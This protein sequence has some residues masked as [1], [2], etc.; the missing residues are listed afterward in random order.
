M[1]NMT[2]IVFY[3]ADEISRKVTMLFLHH[4]LFKYCH[5]PQIESAHAGKP[6][7]ILRPYSLD[8]GH[9]GETHGHMEVVLH[10]G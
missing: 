9:A 10:R 5:N 4:T 1:Y 6:L 7:S 8:D 3:I 2:I